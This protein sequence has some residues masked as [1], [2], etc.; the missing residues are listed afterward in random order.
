MPNYS[1]LSDQIDVFKDKVDALYAT[2]TLDANSLLLLAEALET[3]SNALGVNDIVGATA[4]AI[5]T[6]N[7]ARDAAIT[8]VN[9]TA[10]GTAVTNLQAAYDT[11]NTTYNNLAPRVTS[12]ES[13]STSQTSA[14]ATASSLAA[15]GGWNSWQIHNSGNKALAAADRI[16]V[17]PG[18]N[19]TLTLPATPSLGNAVIIVDAAGTA[20]T[21][22]FTV[23]R[24]GV[25]IMGQAQDLIVNTNNAR[26]QLVY[27]DNTRG[28][29]LV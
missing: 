16:F 6:L 28:W 23:A 26:L 10:N 12:L 1:T 11:L 21:T 15:L 27:S 25:P 2:G 8:V 7:A 13:T 19:M 3:L 24:N 14:I 4:E 20:A 22:N 18:P 5:T 9:G 17:I 29:R